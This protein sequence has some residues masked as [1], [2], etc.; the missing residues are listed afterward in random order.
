[1]SP[2]VIKLLKHI[3]RLSKVIIRHISIEMIVVQKHE[4]ITG[5]VIS[6]LL[7]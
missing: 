3:S 2:G 5:Q 7:Q 4:L 6:N 1:M